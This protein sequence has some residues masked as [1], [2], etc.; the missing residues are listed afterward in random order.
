MKA[1]HTRV[2]RGNTINRTERAAAYCMSEICN[3]DP[4]KQNQGCQRIK[5]DVPYGAIDC[6][7]CSHV[8]VW[9]APVSVAKQ[10]RLINY[11]TMFDVFEWNS[12]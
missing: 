2:N 8:L 9:E 11:R 10:R 1:K 12:R 5:R 3:K 7:F 6:P 4:L